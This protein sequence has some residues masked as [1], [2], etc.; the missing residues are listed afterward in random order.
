MIIFKVIPFSSLSPISFVQDVFKWHHLQKGYVIKSVGYFIERIFNAENLLQRVQKVIHLRASAFLHTHKHTH[1]HTHTHALGL[2][3]FEDPS[4]S[5]WWSELWNI[6]LLILSLTFCGLIENCK[7][8]SK[9]NWKI[10]QP[11]Y[12]YQQHPFFKSHSDTDS[13]RYAS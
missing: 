13:P 8:P 3:T 12:C 1:T 7:I 9:I 5:H 6:F 2:W 4:P 11:F 10:V